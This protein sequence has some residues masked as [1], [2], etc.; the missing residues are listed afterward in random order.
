[1][2]GTVTVR[3]E[4]LRPVRRSTE[5][6]ATVG[7]PA[8][9]EALTAP[10]TRSTVSITHLHR[11]SGAHVVSI[12]ARCWAMEVWVRSESEMRTRKVN[13]E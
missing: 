3:T 9:K 7:A 2:T 8:T 13:V 6:R 5:A 1:M 10:R 4:A 12:H 11:A